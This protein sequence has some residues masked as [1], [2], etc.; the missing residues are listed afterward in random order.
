MTPLPG[1]WTFDLLNA[2]LHVDHVYQGGRKGNASDDPLPH[3]MSVSNQAG[4]RYTGSREAPKMAVL[5]STLKEQDWPDALDRETGIFT[6]FG[7]NRK[8]GRELHDTKRFGNVIL[9]DMF[10]HM[11]RGDRKR[12]PSGVRVRKSGQRVLARR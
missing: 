10:D 5:T 12:G 6:Y 3:L 9:R 4:F 1:S 7:D 2:D 11:H 8:P